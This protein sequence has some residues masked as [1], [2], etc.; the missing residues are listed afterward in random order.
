MEYFRHGRIRKNLVLMALIGILPVFLIL[1][2]TGMEQRRNSIED[3]KKN[4]SLIAHTMALVQEDIT[5]SSRQMLTTLSLLPDIQ[6]VNVKASRELFASVLHENPQYKNI[7]LTDIHGIVLASGKNF[8]SVS[9]GDRKH[10]REALTSKKFAVGEFI[11]ARVGVSE[12]VF[13]FA[14]PVLDKSGQPI[15]VLTTVVDLTSY[16]SFYE[17]SILP[18]NSFVAI[19]D[20]RGIRLLYYPSKSDTNPVGKPIKSDSWEIASKSL[21]PG[22]FTKDGSDGK[23]RIFAFEQVRLTKEADPYIYIWAAV[24]ESAIVKKANEIL[25]RNLLLM[26]LTASLSILVSWVM[27]YRTLIAPLNELVLM[28]RQFATGGLRERS[29]L[30]SKPD[31]LGTLARAFHDMADTLSV[32]QRSLRENEKKYRTLFESSADAISIIDLDTGK[33]LDC[34]NAAVKLHGVE[35]REKFIGLEPNQLSPEFQPNGELSRELAENHIQ[36][37][38]AQGYE[39]FEWT[40]CDM[41]GALIFSI[42]TLSATILDDKRLVFAI[43]RDITNIK[44]AEE[45]REKL[46][47]ELS[48]A[49]EDV[50]KLSGLLPICS[51]CKKIR[52]DKGYWN[53]LEEYFDQHS[54]ISF[55]HGM[56][57]ECAD[58]LYGKESWYKE[59]KEKSK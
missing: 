24:P 20:H 19:T 22:I 15:A 1:L 44:I 26:F 42:V 36:T 16:T 48:K 32:E 33:F 37:A 45:G 41:D 30:A 27:G 25:S 50:K 56:C 52:D 29:G 9:L 23:R 59:M 53:N 31:E 46:I 7:V 51:H 13:P 35:S 12:P 21:T 34:N 55:S 4:I 10:V 47:N 40:H 6:A 58:D 49:L 11:L 3:A 38:F 17:G 18:E 54:D 39:V 8:T 5:K 43:G 57:S 2:Y 28:T 14:T